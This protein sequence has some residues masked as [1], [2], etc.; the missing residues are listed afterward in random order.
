[1]FNPT[2]IVIQAFV[3]QLREM[4]CQTYGVLDPAY[5]DIIAFVGRL[6]LEN[7]AVIQNAELIGGKRR[8]GLGDVDNQLRGAGAWSAFGC[9]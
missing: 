9:A 3:E 5:P 7:I 8:S 4:Y 1:M 6:A 2:Q